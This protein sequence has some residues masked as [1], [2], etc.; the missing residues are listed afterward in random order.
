MHGRFLA[1][2]LRN[3]ASITIITSALSGCLVEDDETKADDSLLSDSE[4]SGSVGDGPVIGA[5]MTVSS[6]D[7]E[8]LAEMNSDS[9]AGYNV[10]V[11]AQGKH[12]PLIIDARGGIDL[13][14]NQEPDFVLLGAIIEPGK[15]SV[16]NVNPFSTIAVE[17][18]RDLPGGINKENLSVAEGLVTKALNNGLSSLAASGP[19]GTRIDSSNITE[20]VRASESLG[21]TIRRTRDLQ[22]MF[23]RASSGDGVVQSIASDLIDGIV[24]G[25]GGPRVDKRTSAIATIVAVQVL[26]ESAQNEL[27]VNGQNA[28]EAMTTAIN[29]VSVDPVSIERDSTSRPLDSFSG[30]LATPDMIE[31]IRVGLDACLAVEDNPKMLELSASFGAIEPGMSPMAV[32]N[33]I[34]DDYRQT[35]DSAL[36]GI[37]DSSNTVIDTVNEVA[38]GSSG[39]TSNDPAPTEPEPTEPAPT[40]PEPTEPAPTDPE[41]TEPA[42]T[43]PEPTEPAPTDPEPTEPAP[44]DPEPTNRAPNITGTPPSEINADSSYSFTPTA[45]DPDDDTLS[46]SVSGLP[47]WANFSTSSGSISGTPTEAHVGVY[48]DIRITVTD[49]A[50]ASATLGPFSIT[51]Q[52]ISLGS[53]T[54]NWTPPTAN[55]DGTP[56]VDLAG[57]KI[58]WG[59]TPGSYPNSVTIDNPGV[60]SYVV[61]NLVPGTYDFVATSYN[62]A[63]VESSHSNPAT[64][65]VQ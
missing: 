50:N 32:R 45:S 62:A 52:G 15:K 37:A 40:D 17:V 34:P 42:P 64:K 48:S 61:D 46:F 29:Q 44:T 30:I 58:Y 11:R 31:A 22:L 47:G 2:R 20:I 65:I 41:P 55:E 16:G 7:G 8:A 5:T 3:V 24:D 54:L 18:A 6:Y 27:H 26:L 57:Y 33:I 38:R 49:T 59:T 39:I 14:T 4:L 23:G 36:L 9:S 19:M 28:T 35:L 43:D 56:L 63:G 12:Y 53:I 13:V 51:V 25:L 21:E 10:V 60:S 1:T